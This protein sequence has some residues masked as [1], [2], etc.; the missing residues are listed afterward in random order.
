MEVKELVKSNH[1]KIEELTIALCNIAD[2]KSI[3]GNGK[4]IMH[5][6]AFPLKHSFA[7]GVYI[8]QMDMKQGS[9]VIGAIH[10]DEHVWFLLTGNLTI[11][12]KESVEDYIAPCYIISKPGTQRVLYANEDSI[13]INVH[14]NPTNTRNVKELENQLVSINQEEYEKYVQTKNN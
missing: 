9:I 7:D 14:K 6:E 10:K 4:D 13:F 8:R 5:H 3:I 11:G 2:D 1:K 12:T